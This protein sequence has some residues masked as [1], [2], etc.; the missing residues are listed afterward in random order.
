MKIS[1]AVSLV[2]AIAA[3]STGMAQAQEQTR[4]ADGFVKTIGVCTHFQYDGVYTNTF[5]DGQTLQ[6]RLV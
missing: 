4:S 6:N 1:N 2:A 3:L 5:G